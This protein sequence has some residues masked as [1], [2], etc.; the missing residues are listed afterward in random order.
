[1]L[2]G[3]HGVTTEFDAGSQ[4]Y[5]VAL[6]NGHALIKVRAVNLDRLERALKIDDDEEESLP[7]SWLPAGISRSE[8]FPLVLACTLSAM[9]AFALLTIVWLFTSATLDDASPDMKDMKEMKDSFLQLIGAVPYPAM[10]PPLMPPPSPPPPLA[11]PPHWP[12]P[13]SPP[14]P[15]PPPVPLRPPGLAHVA[16]PPAPPGLE[17][18]CC[19][20][21]NK[22]AS[23]YRN[24]CQFNGGE[25]THE[26]SCAATELK[27]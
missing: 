21:Q 3:E 19:H 6:D 7:R 26:G 22:V 5:T 10:P 11:P 8:Y 20:V 4:R 14:P 2:N 18:C 1:M 13:P 25:C 9:M 15:S 16:M 12:Q 24:F 17:W 27:A 23:L